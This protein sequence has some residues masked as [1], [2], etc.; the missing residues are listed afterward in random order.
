M[1]DIATYDLSKLFWERLLR[2]SAFRVAKVH[3]GMVGYSR[4]AE[5]GED[6]MVEKT[7]S[8]PLSTA[9]WLHLLTSY[10]KPTAVC[11]IGTY[12]GKSTF[13]MASGMVQAGTIH[14]CDGNNACLSEKDLNRHSGP[15]V[16]T[17]PKTMSP[18]MFERVKLHGHKQ[19]DL[20]FFDG[21]LQAQ[22]VDL[23]AD[24]SGSDTIYAF[25]DVEGMEKG[26]TNM[27]AL[28]G[29]GLLQIMPPDPELLRPYGVADRST[30]GLLVPASLF[31]FTAQ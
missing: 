12:I 22:D 4:T 28:S 24:L 13:A 19:I 27:A 31:R 18:V 11:E 30:L 10:I 15:T 29:P 6:L 25:D 1:F 20:F 23:I 2:L 17:Y 8:I 16:I 5:A 9:I 7:G 3:D 14:T 21:R 26:V